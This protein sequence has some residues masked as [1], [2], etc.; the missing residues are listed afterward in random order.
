MSVKRLFV[1]DD[2]GGEPFRSTRLLQYV[3]TADQESF[4]AFLTHH[5]LVFVMAG[6]KQIRIGSE[7]YRIGPGELFLIPRGEYVMSE[8]I[9]RNRGFRSLMLFFSR[10]LAR[11]TLSSLHLAETVPG[12]ERSGEA[13]AADVLSAA[14]VQVIPGTDEIARVFAALDAYGLRESEYR[15]E[16]VRLKFRE[17]VILLL[18]SPWRSR[19]LSFLRD[20]ARSGLP[21]L[22]R[23]VEAHLYEPVTLAD[24]ARMSGRSLSAFKRD[25]SRDFGEAPKTWMRRKKLERAAYLLRTT[26]LPLEEV[27]ESCG[28]ADGAHL[29]RLFRE[30]YGRTPSAYR[31]EHSRF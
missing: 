9:A 19:I 24:L 18:D 8:Y 23:V 2:F 30:F 12:R 13:A 27:A 6:V 14:A 4:D 31:A 5:A 22:A 17:L 21:E 15:E 25:F 7:Q 16:L 3:Q 26:E 29:S 11:E 20:A 10:Q 28:L 1:P